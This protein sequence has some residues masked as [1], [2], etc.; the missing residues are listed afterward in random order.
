MLPCASVASPLSLRTRRVSRGF[1]GK[2][3]LLSLAFGSLFI[4]H[5]NAYFLEGPSWTLGGNVTF[6]MRLGTAPQTLIDGNVSW[7]VAAAPAFGVW[8]QLLL[9]VQ[10]VSVVNPSAPVSSGDGVNAIAFSST[11]FGQSFG[12]GVL[13]VT[14]YRFTGSRMTE[15]DVLFN[16]GQN[17]DS[18]RGPLRFGSNFAAIGDI[19]RVLI[20]ELG[21]A[22]GLAHPDQHN[23]SVD[24]IMNSLI[25]NRET[26]SSDDTAGAQSLYGAAAP[27]VLKVS[28]LTR[29]ANGH[30]L[31]QCSGAPSTSYTVQ[32]SPDLVTPF[33]P[34][35]GITTNGAGIFQFDDAGVA[36]ATKGFYRLTSP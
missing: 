36:G 3:A 25:S 6:Q 10:F 26:A 17:W 23:Q 11:V 29:L 9:R 4:H 33:S 24:A 28:S 30:V 18:Y 7:D 8:D 12:S 35:A 1:A 31:L 5:A 34:L 14:T 13:A 16:T 2:L 19:R 27:V 15:A 32:F 21:H 20:H 22:L